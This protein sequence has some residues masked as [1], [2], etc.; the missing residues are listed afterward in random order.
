[1]LWLRQARTYLRPIAS[2]PPRAAT[3]RPRS[4]MRD[5][6]PVVP[7]VDIGSLASC[8]GLRRPKARAL[9]EVQRRDSD[10]ENER[11][12]SRGKATPRKL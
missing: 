10:A 4:A 3:R 5:T 2:A 11:P 9:E 6:S 1:M 7:A 8:L 12:N